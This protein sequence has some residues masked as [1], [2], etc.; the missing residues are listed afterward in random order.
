MDIQKTMEFILEQQA[1]TAAG[2]QELKA[3]AERHQAAIEQHPDDLQIH[4]EWKIAMSQ[5]LQ[6]LAGQMKNGF[7]EI[8]VKHKELANAHKATEESLNI[9][10]RTV[11]DILPRLPRQ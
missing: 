3:A 2:L 9:L 10:I 4:T 1:A 5:A 8:A 6:D 7:V 11:Q